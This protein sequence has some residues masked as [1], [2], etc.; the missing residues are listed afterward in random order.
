MLSQT[1]K[2]RNMQRY[3]ICI[4]VFMGP[5]S[6]K[7]PNPGDAKPVKSPKPQAPDPQPN[8]TGC[9]LRAQ[10]HG[11]LWEPARVS[12]VFPDAAKKLASR[13]LGLHWTHALHP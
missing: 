3:C 1:E 2:V 5:R 4:G 7:A 10:E 9:S 13:Q 12:V 8:L 6:P 11:K